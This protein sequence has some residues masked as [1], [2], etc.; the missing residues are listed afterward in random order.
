MV[1][2]PPC[3][4]GLSSRLGSKNHESRSIRLGGLPNEPPAGRACESGGDLPA[5]DRVCRGLRARN[6]ASRATWRLGLDGVPPRGF[7][8]GSHGE[9]RAWHSDVLRLF[10]RHIS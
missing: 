8:L 5:L 10:W 9:L 7:H 6:R 3:C 2:Q 1:C 4:G